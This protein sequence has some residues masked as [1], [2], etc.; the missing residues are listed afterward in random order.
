M[1]LFQKFSINHWNY[2]G[3]V[4]VRDVDLLFVTSVS[5]RPEDMR[6]YKIALS[7]SLSLA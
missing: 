4:F 1:C 5:S 2:V 7:V 3:E 6:D